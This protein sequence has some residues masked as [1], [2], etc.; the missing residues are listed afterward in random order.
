MSMD[1]ASRYEAGAA[2]GMVVAH[3]AAV[4][5]D[6]PALLSERGDRTFAELNAEANRLVRAWRERGVTAG[7]GVALMVSN[8]PEFAAVVAATQRSGLRVTPVNWH[9]TADEVGRRYTVD[10]MRALAYLWQV[11]W[12]DF[13]DVVETS[14][15]SRDFYRTRR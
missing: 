8:R 11:R 14:A 13:L 4:Q 12:T 3:W 1:A 2:H 15:A 5:P 7:D 9:L 6:A 10:E